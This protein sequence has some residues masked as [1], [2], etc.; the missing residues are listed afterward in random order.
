MATLNEISRLR[1]YR[2]FGRELPDSFDSFPYLRWEDGEPWVE[3]NILALDHTFGGEYVDALY[4]TMGHL[5]RYANFLET[6]GLT[7]NYFRKDVMSHSVS[8]LW[9]Q[10][11]ARLT[12]A[13]E[14][15]PFLTEYIQTVFLFYWFTIKSC[16]LSLDD[17]L[18]A[19]MET[20]IIFLENLPFQ[21]FPG[22]GKVNS[23]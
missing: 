17:E 23:M 1:A 5:T 9:L 10:I 22:L 2:F 14:E 4:K 3:A 8:R 11:D 19:S 18:R 20:T 12:I 16:Q 15:E 21:F 13:P 7:W 6:E